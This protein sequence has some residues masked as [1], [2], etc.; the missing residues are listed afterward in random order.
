MSDP[1]TNVEIEDVLS[2]IRRLVT[3]SGSKTDVQGAT[4]ADPEPVVEEQIEEAEAALETVAETAVEAAVEADANNALD[5]L[6]LTPSL[7]IAEPVEDTSEAGAGTQE[8]ESALEVTTDELVEVAAEDAAELADFAE[9]EPADEGLKSRIEQLETA[10]ADKVDDWEDDTGGAGDNAAAPF[11]TL[12]WEDHSDVVQDE[13]EALHEAALFVAP[14]PERE[15]EPE[16]DEM[17]EPLEKATAES[18]YVAE[19]ADD[20]ED[21]EDFE[22]SAEDS[23]IDEDMLREMVSDIVR[24]ELQGALGERIT[25]NVRKLVRREIH[26]ALMAQE[27]E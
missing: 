3:E 11:E 7:R 15:A 19:D 6:V 22:F 1:V 27:L 13:T 5:K 26:R 12:Q 25:R 23:V 10:V 14:Q 16:T 2:S 18:G 17:V 9:V 8:P 21:L 4:K 24:Q 20:E